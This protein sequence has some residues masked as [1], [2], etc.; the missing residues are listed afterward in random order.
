MRFKTPRTAVGLDIGSSSIKVVELA[1][2]GDRVHLLKWGR[3]DLLPD[4]IVDGEVMDRHHVVET[5]QNLMEECDIKNRRVVISVSGR[6]VIVKRVTM[7]R[8]T[9]EEA[10]EAIRWEA[11]QHVPYDIADV[12]L[13]YHLLDLD[14][15]PKEMQVLLVATKQEVVHGRLE[16]VREAGLTAAAIDVDSFAIQN[17]IEWGHDLSP[18]EAIAMVNVGGELTNMHVIRAG[19]PFYT[20]DLATGTHTLVESIRKTYEI[21][22][23]EAIRALRSGGHDGGIDLTDLVHSFADDLKVAIDRAGLFLRT[24]GDADSIDRI[25]VTGGGSQVVGL[26]EALAEKNNVPV[27]A[28]NPLRRMALPD[29]DN[30]LAES[31]GREL[32]VSIGLALREALAA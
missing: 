4:A 30:N 29:D 5:I 9:E 15:G 25:I 28:G 24:S 18:E 27:E 8:M 17:A 2:R 22:R 19:A 3:A 1:S 21:S 32:T 26:V 6:G 20:Q 14:A 16:I 7:A 11:E 13:D 23:D 31:H 12:L 10:D